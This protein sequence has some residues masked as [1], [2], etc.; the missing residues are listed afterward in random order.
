MVLMLFIIITI[1]G[2]AKAIAVLALAGDTGAAA[3]ASST[4]ALWPMV[5][6]QQ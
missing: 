3:S 4:A 1:N 2:A 5:Y 6:V